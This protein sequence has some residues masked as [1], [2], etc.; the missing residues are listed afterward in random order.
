MKAQP[1][2]PKKKIHWLRWILIAV[3]VAVLFYSGIFV[4][5]TYRAAHDLTL[6]NGSSKDNDEVLECGASA[7][8]IALGSPYRGEGNPT[9]SFTTDGSD[10]LVSARHF[11]HGIFD[12]K[13]G[14]AGIWIGDAATPPSYDPQRNVVSHT[15]V[16]LAVQEGGHKIVKLSAGQYWLWASNG[17][18]LVVASC[19]H[20]S[21]QQPNGIAAPVLQN[22]YHGGACDDQA[23][24]TKHEREC[25]VQ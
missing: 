8:Q 7:T 21:G 15:K 5:A 23:Y 22:I 4:Y 11:E 6:L 9:A 17:G 19:G 20:I 13:V 12:S 24:Y 3:G 1:K 16:E 14:R 25:A 10:I 18:D 2:Q